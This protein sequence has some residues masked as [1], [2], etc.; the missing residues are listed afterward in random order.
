MS[1]DSNS[2]SNKPQ[3]RFSRLVLDDGDEQEVPQGVEVVHTETDG[4]QLVLWLRE[5][6]DNRDKPNSS[7]GEEGDVSLNF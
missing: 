1:D 6:I 7:T 3:Y 4:D 5:Q 2:G